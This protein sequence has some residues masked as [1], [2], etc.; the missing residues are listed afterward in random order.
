MNED[1]AIRT[2]AI[3]EKMTNV[4][5]KG[6]NKGKAEGGDSDELIAMFTTALQKKSAANNNQKTSSYNFA[7]S[8]S[9]ID[10]ETMSKVIANWDTSYTISQA[11]SMFSNTPNVSE[12]LYT[13][14]LDFS[15]CA[16]LLAVFL[17]SNVKK[18]KV[19]DARK[20]IAGHNGMSTMFHS[21]KQLES[22]DEFYPSTG[23]NKTGFNTTFEWCYALTH[24]RFMSEIAQSGLNLSYS[25]LDKESI[26][27]CINQL[28]STTTGLKVTLSLSA[29]NKA[30]ET[31]TGANDGST[32]EVWNLL[33]A[34]KTNWTI[35]LV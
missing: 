28:S 3:A 27:S 4:Y 18:L 14:K 26:K 29:V 11:I 34:T 12:A 2:Q 22:I 6:Y 31:V 10:D 19:I 20:T 25:P 21:C 7:F 13:D 23:T 5:I 33:I 17:G 35:N 15:N 24:I 9:S 8:Q 1:L 30:F 32:S 16:S